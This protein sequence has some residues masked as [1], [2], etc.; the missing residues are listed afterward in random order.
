MSSLEV[1][2][3]RRV[4]AEARF[5]ALDM[6]LADTQ[7][8]HAQLEDRVLAAERQLAESREQQRALERERQ[9]ASFAMRSLEARRA[10]LA[11]AIETAEQACSVS[12]EQQKAH[13]GPPDS[14]TQ[15]HKAA[16]NRRWPSSWR[17]KDLGAQRSQ[18]DDLTTKLRASDERR[19]Q[20]E[21]ELGGLRV[22]EFQLKEQAARLG[23][24][25]YTQLLADAQVDLVAI[26]QSLADGSVRL[27]GLQ[28]EIDRLN[29]EIAA[30]APSTWRRWMNWVLR[31]SARHSWMPS[32]PI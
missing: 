27:M 9:E 14:T 4:T 15:R 26:A 28:T 22:T 11:R 31:V 12:A 24:E 16:C 10:E 32:P 5:E 3:E 19:L 8:R 6:Q 21:R 25:Q 20:L 23:F 2:Q 17:V 30:W 29:R 13:E 18:Y 7:E 1:L